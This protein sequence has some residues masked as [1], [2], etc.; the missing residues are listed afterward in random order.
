MGKTEISDVSSCIPSD[1]LFIAFWNVEN[2]FDAESADRPEKLRRMIGKD[3][4][5]WND[6]L[7]DSKLG[8][9]SKII[10]SM[11]SGAG[12]DILG[13][14][15]AENRNV[16]IKLTKKIFS[17]GGRKYQVAHA[18]ASDNRGVDVAFLYDP[19]IAGT[20]PD[21]MFQHWII[22]RYA[23]RELF[24]V[25][26]AIDGRTIV[27]VGNHWPARSAGQYE[28]EPY[29]MTAGETLSYYIERIQQE[30][31]DD[32]AI[33]VLGDFNDEPFSRS[34]TEYALSLNDRRRMTEG[35]NP[36]LLNLMWPI[37]ASGA[38]SYVYEGQWYMLD[39]IMVSRGVV[40]GNCGWQLQGDAQIE[41]VTLMSYP[42]KIGPRR[43]GIKSSE[44]DTAGFSDHYPV[45]VT[46]QR[47]K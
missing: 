43:F 35:K 2:L 7:L 47:K 8:Q 18:D 39:Q 34:I 6:A 17:E 40:N 31:G 12:P 11:N 16:L 1:K 5:G 14:C 46:L 37:L 3:L 9:L 19:N 10:R 26:F 21:K 24:Q 29:R 36:Y 15:E 32:V 44:R 45:S 20:S 33:I 42:K 4:T 25:N 22:K 28:S 27:V 30:L 41:A 38:G 23:T 13:V